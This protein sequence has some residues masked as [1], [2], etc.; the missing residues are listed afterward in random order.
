MDKKTLMR[1]CISLAR[2]ALGKTSPNPMVGALLYKDGKIIAEDY[3]RKAGAPHAEA[4]VLNKA[5]KDAN[6]AALFVSLEP[7]CHKEKRTPPCTDAIIKAK[8]KE[9]IIAAL[10]PNPMVAGKGAEILKNA[11]ISVQIGIE[12]KRA[13]QINEAY[14]KFIT[15][16]TPFV[17]MKTAM[18][19]DGKIAEPNGHSKWITC[20][21]S[22]KLVHSIRASVDAVLTAIGTVKIDNP[23]LTARLKGKKDPLRIV[24]DP[25]CDTPIDSSVANV[26]PKT[27]IVTKSENDK[28]N[29]LSKKGVEFIFY[30]DSLDLKWLMRELGQRQITSLLVEGGSSLTSH[31]LEDGIVDKV[32]FFIAPKIIGGKDAYVPVG[33]SFHRT[34][35]DPL[36][37]DNLTA[38]KIG[39]DF[40]LEG[41]VR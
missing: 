12:E 7:C 13:K 1:R 26:P 3:H 4:L 9:I 14:F 19:L 39:S 18:T 35:N 32:M 15:T 17:I 10:D 11:G 40:L 30:E 27:I 2:K 24:I 37:I 38:K 33:G 22:R 5:Q 6:G 36:F 23:K 31:A 29:A 20:D 34:L 21:K 25:F 8:V 28:T 41:Y 16:T